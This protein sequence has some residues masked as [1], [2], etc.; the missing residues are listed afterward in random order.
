MPSQSTPAGYVPRRQAYLAF[1]FVKVHN[2]VLERQ[3]FGRVC[4]GIC[5]YH[6]TY[7]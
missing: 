7:L 6:V 3:P 2:H 4:A 5:K 1:V